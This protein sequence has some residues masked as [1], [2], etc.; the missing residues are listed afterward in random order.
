MVR[1]DA[2]TVVE[3]GECVSVG[4]AVRFKEMVRNPVFSLAVRTPDGRIVYDTTTRWMNIE[5]PE[6]PAPPAYGKVY[7]GS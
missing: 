5:T 6:Y 2:V 3:S 4:I 1:G 7:F